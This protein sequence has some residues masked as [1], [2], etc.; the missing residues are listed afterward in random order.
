MKLIARLLIIVVACLVIAGCFK[1]NVVVTV[2]PD[3]SGTVTQQVLLSAEALKQL[4]DLGSIGGNKDGDPL[5]QMMSD[6]K[7]REM[8]QRMGDDVKVEKIEKIENED[9]EGVK[10]TFSFSDVTK[11]QVNLD[12]KELSNG[13]AGD[14]D[15]PLTFEFTKGSPATLVVKMTHKGPDAG[16]DELEQDDASME[17][18]AQMFKG[19]K[20]AL[21]IAVG[22]TIEQT[23]ARHQEA[24]QITIAE[25]PF[26]IVLKD[27]AVLK[28]LTSAKSWDAASK[29]LETVPGVKVEPKETVTVSFK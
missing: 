11:I 5:S 16:E 14:T 24:S 22:G 9:G 3:G 19:A 25:I 4:Q 10:T 21:K 1:A 8:A 6:D 27:K 18:A 20:M 29:I 2:Q 17:M 13:E 7:A 15:E 23:D 12:L 26:D 28:E